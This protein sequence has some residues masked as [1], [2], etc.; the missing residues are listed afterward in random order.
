MSIV[1]VAS[2]SG[3]G[4]NALVTIDENQA[5]K[6]YS[7]MI[8]TISNYKKN[9]K[10]FDQVIRQNGVNISAIYLGTLPQKE[11][12]DKKVS[13]MV[14]FSVMIL[15]IVHS[16]NNKNEDMNEAT[17][18]I[19]VKA[20]REKIIDTSTIKEESLN[21]KLKYAYVNEYIHLK[22]CQRIVI[23]SSQWNSKILKGDILYLVNVEATKVSSATYSTI[24]F[25]NASSIQRKEGITSYHL[26]NLFNNS[27]FR[28]SRLN[29]IIPLPT[30]PTIMNDNSSSDIDGLQYKH[31]NEK[32][33]TYILKIKSETEDQLIDLLSIPDSSI[34]R[35]IESTESEDFFFKDKKKN[36]EESISLKAKYIIL[37]WDGNYNGQEKNIKVDINAHGNSVNSFKIRNVEPWKKLAPLMIKN[38]DHIIFG[39]LN[40]NGTLEMKVNCDDVKTT[41][42]PFNIDFGITLYVDFMIFDIITF[43]EEYGIPVSENYVINYF[44]SPSGKSPILREPEDKLMVCLNELNS[45]TRSYISQ[46]KK[47]QENISFKVI[48]DSPSLNPMWKEEISS[49]KPEDG[50]SLLSGDRKYR[51]K[52]IAV[53]PGAMQYIFLIFNNEIKELKNTKNYGS[54]LLNISNSFDENNDP[55]QLL[56]APHQNNLHSQDEDINNNINN[57]NNNNN[58]KMVE[59]KKITKHNHTDVPIKDKDSTIINDMTDNTTKKVSFKK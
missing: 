33:K 40:R 29:K 35:Y 36:D 15:P 50:D 41:N 16:S 23:G 11:R 20:E 53:N 49:M 38:M 25:Y 1:P 3:N 6:F 47:L 39:S 14:Q 44:E 13:P 57:N 55:I 24:Y 2:T 10:S 8:G 18:R 59:T 48:T 58:N 51:S 4:N 45:D 27:S 21:S 52:V 5:K 32:D 56:D 43:I 28:N 42:L 31:D 34:A 7:N 9:K 17:I 46:Q 19:P 26:F 22:S 37:Q 30:F 12:E 54:K